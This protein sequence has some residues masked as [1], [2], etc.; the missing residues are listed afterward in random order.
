MARDARRDTRIDLAQ[1]KQKQ[2]RKLAGILRQ[3]AYTCVP[4]GTRL[5]TCGGEAER[6]H[7]TASR[8]L[9]N[10]LDLITI[11]APSLS[12]VTFLRESA[13]PEGGQPSTVY[14]NPDRLYFDGSLTASGT[15]V[16]TQRST[17]IYPE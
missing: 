2:R 11:F 17:R 16:T 1:Q 5:S 4:R 15:Y 6:V 9:P 3:P 13:G 7:N 8:K 10:R 14:P 12:L